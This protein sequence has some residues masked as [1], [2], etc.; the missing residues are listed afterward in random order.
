MKHTEEELNKALDK[1]IL[2]LFLSPPRTNRNTRPAPSTFITTIFASLQRSWRE[3]IPTA[4]TNGIVLYI[5]PDWFMEL[6]PQMRCTLLAHECWHVAFLHCDGTRRGDR[7][8]KTWNA[9]CDYAIN[10]MMYEFG[11]QFDIGLLDPKYNDMSAEAIY[12]ILIKDAPPPLP[13]GSDIEDFDPILDPH[14]KQ[15]VI[16][17]IVRALQTSKMNPNEHG[18]VPGAVAEQIRELLEPQLP[19]YMVLARYLSERSNQSRTWH[20]PHRRYAPHGMYLPSDGGED[21]LGHTLWGCDDSGSMSVE[22]L[23]FMNS[24]MKGCKDLLCPA[25]M[26]VVS[27]DTQIQDSWEFTD[28]TDLSRL[29]F[30]GRGGTNLHALFDH[31]LKLKQRPK[32]IVVMSD[33]ECDEPPN[34]GID[35]LWIRFGKGGF[36]P[37]YGK[38]IQVDR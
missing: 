30:H 14:A 33:L 11:Y 12:D 38:T 9:A 5:N 17:S 20:R 10:N 16:G 32:L 8:P 22:N 28:E 6:E 21:G 36:K 13:F 7:D 25:S 3:D 26:S 1:A 4:C 35:V 18:S 37:T 29:T 15:Q 2:G 34:P 23:H 19:W 24:E 31:A 27:F